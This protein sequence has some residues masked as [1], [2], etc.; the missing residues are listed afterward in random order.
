MAMFSLADHNPSV[1]AILHVP[2]IEN[3][4]AAE[5]TD[6]SCMRIPSYH[7]RERTLVLEVLLPADVASL[8]PKFSRKAP[9]IRAG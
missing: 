5:V 8:K 7:H 2:E 1:A 3:N 9:A 4:S 6:S